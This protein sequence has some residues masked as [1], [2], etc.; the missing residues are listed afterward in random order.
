MRDAW[1]RGAPDGTKTV[2]IEALRC[3]S[4]QA[5]TWHVVLRFAILSDTLIST[6]LYILYFHRVELPSCHIWPREESGGSASAVLS[7]ITRVGLKPTQV[8]FL[9]AISACAQAANSRG[10][11]ILL[12]EMIDEVRQAFVRGRRSC[13]ILIVHSV[14]Y[15]RGRP[16][17]VPPVLG[18]AVSYFAV[19]VSFFPLSPRPAKPSVLGAL[20]RKPVLPPLFFA[21]L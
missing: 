8:S 2:P 5:G 19:V 17:K 18:D 3:Q 4:S 6:P 10:A 13:S 16:T 9:P 21:A 12:G 14:N 20:S 11:L 15:H 1:S 7:R